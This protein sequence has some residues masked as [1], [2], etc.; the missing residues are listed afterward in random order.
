M[1]ICRKTE[2]V[3]KPVIDKIQNLQFDLKRTLSLT[4]SRET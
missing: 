1:K 3:T 4:Y 2:F